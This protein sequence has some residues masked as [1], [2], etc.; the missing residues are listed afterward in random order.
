MNKMKKN[1]LEANFDYR[2]EGTK[3][4]HAISKNR[5]K[6]LEVLEI[7]TYIAGQ[8]FGIPA[9]RGIVSLLIL[10]MLTESQTSSANTN[11]Q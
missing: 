8:N 3:S 1:Q 11:V 10:Q 4:N 5:T 6:S 7:S 2:N 9:V